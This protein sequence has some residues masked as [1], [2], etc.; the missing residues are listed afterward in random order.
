MACSQVE[1]IGGEAVT[2]L[3]AILIV[4]LVLLLVGGV[5][6]SRWY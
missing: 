3:V 1:A 5:G 4:L 6:Y 2:I